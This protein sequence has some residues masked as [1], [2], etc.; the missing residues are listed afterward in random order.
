M[1]SLTYMYN[2]TY[3]CS[4]HTYK[5]RCHKGRISQISHPRLGSQEWR[6][7]ASG[8]FLPHRRSRC[9]SQGKIIYI[10]INICMYIYIY[11]YVNKNKLP[12][13]YIQTIHDFFYPI[14]AVG[15]TSKVNNVSKLYIYTYIYIYSC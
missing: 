15:A 3:I 12:Y 6:C 8:F 2:L 10:N 5:C 1:Y 14:E 11:I 7:Q 4:K 13:T 9:N